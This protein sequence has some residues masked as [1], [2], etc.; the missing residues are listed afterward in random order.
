MELIHPDATLLLRPKTSLN[1]MVVEVDPGTEGETPSE[2]STIPLAQTEP[3]INPDAF[4]AT[5]DADTREY[6]PLLL[7]GGGRGLGGQRHASSRPACAASSPSPTTSP[8]S[9]ARWRSGARTRAASIHNFRLLTDELGRH[10]AELARLRRLLQRG[11]RQLRQPAGRDPES[12]QR[13]PADPAGDPERPRQLQPLSRS[14]RPALLALIPQ[15]QAL[16]P[17]LEATQQ[18]FTRDAVADPR[19]DPA[20][21]PPDP[22][23]RSATWTRRRAAGQDRRRP[24]ATP[25]PTS[26]AL[27]NELAYNPPGSS[28]R[29]SSSTSPG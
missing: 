1:D 18:L 15:A 14:L 27:L 16:K 6:L 10:D 4:L 9:A 23:D 5:L 11:A 19:P 29:A 3:N 17:A 20:L 2:G 7:E 8:G 25:S 13:V 12:L 28:R 22:A 26:T 21:H 24:R